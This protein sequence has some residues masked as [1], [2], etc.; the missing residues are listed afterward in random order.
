[1]RQFDVDPGGHTP[2]HTHGHEHEVYVLEGTGVVLEGDVEHP[3][4]PGHG[5]FRP[6]QAVA[7]V[8]QHRRRAAAVSLP[9]SASAARHDGPLRRGL[10][11]RL[12]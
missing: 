11:L 4:R 5:R 1:M 12:T 7:P 6:A 2:K 10:R 8:S 9:D 3:L